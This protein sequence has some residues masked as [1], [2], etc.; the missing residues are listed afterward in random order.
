MASILA[1]S[2][3]GVSEWLLLR[4]ARIC[5]AA[6][7]EVTALSHCCND[8]MVKGVDVPSFSEVSSIRSDDLL[9]QLTCFG[10]GDPFFA[11]SS[12]LSSTFSCSFLLVELDPME[13]L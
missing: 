5:S 11:S 10:R 9:D 2:L 8:V 3:E 1:V 6:C 4:D 12:I 7:A 13:T